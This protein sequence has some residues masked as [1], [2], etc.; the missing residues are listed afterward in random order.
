[1][2]EL[3][4]S[5]F[6]FVDYF[7]GRILFV[8]GKKV[9]DDFNHASSVSTGSKPHLDP[10]IAAYLYYTLFLMCLLGAGFWIYW[11]GT[12]HRTEKFSLLIFWQSSRKTLF[13]FLLFFLL[14]FFLISTR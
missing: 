6:E 4:V 1:M 13:V 3:V 2:F 11:L 5:K 7:I 12:R 8:F 9:T 10:T 14:L